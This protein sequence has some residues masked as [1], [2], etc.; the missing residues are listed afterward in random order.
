[1]LHLSL[2][3]KYVSNQRFRA[4]V[5]CAVALFLSSSL[6][7]T[8]VGQFALLGVFYFGIRL[9]IIWRTRSQQV[10]L[11]E[12]ELVLPAIFTGLKAKA[13][14]IDAIQIFGL[15]REKGKGDC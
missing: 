13:V 11:S 4:L 14:P 12:T 10:S 9:L 2:S 15:Q 3:P 7:R 5:W 1:M 8:I 6:E